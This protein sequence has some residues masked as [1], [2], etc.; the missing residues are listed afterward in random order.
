MIR[1]ITLFALYV[2]SYIPLFLILAI[3][4]ID[5]KLTD[6]AHNFIGVREILINNKI[7][8][9][10]FVISVMAILYYVVF[11]SVNQKYGFTNPEK[12]RSSSNS[13][14]EYLSYLATYILPFVGLKFDSW[15]NI[16]AS[17]ILFLLIGFIYIRTN[18]IYAN[19]TLALFGYNIYEVEVASNQKRTVIFKGLINNDKF[20]KFKLISGNVYFLKE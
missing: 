5:D 18:L 19:P 8:I 15:N 17:G 20:Y 7:T 1:K 14:V 12:V 4:N 3:Q 11:S 9:I 10:F 13:G 6:A 2:V 16:L